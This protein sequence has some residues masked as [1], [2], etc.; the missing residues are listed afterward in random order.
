MKLR[1]KDW[2][3]SFSPVSKLKKKK[4]RKMRQRSPL[5]HRS[6]KPSMSA[7]RSQTRRLLKRWSSM[8]TLT[9]NSKIL[10]LSYR[11]LHK[12]RPARTQATSL[13]TCSPN[14]KMTKPVSIQKS[15]NNIEVSS[16]CRSR[17]LKRSYESRNSVW[18]KSLTLWRISIGHASMA[19]ALRLLWGLKL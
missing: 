10:K 15:S 14:G 5:W 11:G 9:R 13:K 7:S 19:S 16:G 12:P 3:K 2:L 6:K 1:G 17:I 8:R 18:R 4:R